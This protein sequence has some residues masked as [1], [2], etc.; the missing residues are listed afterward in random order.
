M[1][2]LTKLLLGLLT[3]MIISSAAVPVSPNEDETIDRIEPIK[4]QLS[5][6]IEIDEDRVLMIPTID[7]LII[8]EQKPLSPICLIEDSSNLPR[9][10]L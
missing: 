9:R 1:E 6:S 8:Y 2:S 10:T 4:A 5:E 7:L 3:V